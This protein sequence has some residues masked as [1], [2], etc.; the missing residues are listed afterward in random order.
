MAFARRELL[1]SWPAY[2]VRPAADDPAGNRYEL[3]TG[4]HELLAGFVAAVE[5]I[6]SLDW[7]AIRTHERAL[8][9]RFLRGVPDEVELYG[10][11]TMDGRVPTFSFNIPGHSPE[12]VATQL[13][14]A[15]QIAVGWGSHYA[16]EIMKRLRLNPDSGTIRAG[17]IHYNTD[18]EVDRLLAGI[19]SLL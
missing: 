10:L 14:V 2:K 9:E 17:F 13:A 11:R 6:E 8:G 19:R 3:G 15:H 12:E 1:T 5:Y 7:E 18:A 4:Q 16:V